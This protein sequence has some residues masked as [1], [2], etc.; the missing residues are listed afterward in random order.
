MLPL[1]PLTRLPQAERARL[2]A[3]PGR[4]QFAP[5]PGVLA[6]DPLRIIARLGS[7]SK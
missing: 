1:E 7:D 4:T 3:A 2:E 5:T 6:L